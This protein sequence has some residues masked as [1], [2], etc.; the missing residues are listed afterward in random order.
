M[1][2]QTSSEEPGID[3][4][5]GMESSLRELREVFLSVGENL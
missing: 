3:K 1:E 4:A 5:Y 2:K